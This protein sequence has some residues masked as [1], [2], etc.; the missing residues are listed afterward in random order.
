MRATAL[1][2]DALRPPVV[3]IFASVVIPFLVGVIAGMPALPVA[4]I[5]FRVFRVFAAAQDQRRFLSRRVFLLVF[6][7]HRSFHR[8]IG[9]SGR[10]RCAAH[11]VVP[12]SRQRLGE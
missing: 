6:V 2:T 11:L 12:H 3:V 9:W 8:T 10:I 5:E 1:A 4:L 7:A